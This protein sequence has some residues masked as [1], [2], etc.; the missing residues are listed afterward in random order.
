MLYVSTVAQERSMP[1]QCPR[2]GGKVQRNTTVSK[3][4]G[5]FGALLGAAI[6]PMQC[7]GCGPILTREFPSAVRK[8]I[9]LG[10]IGLV[11]AGVAVLAGAVAVFMLW[12][13]SRQ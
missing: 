4:G 8:R 5:V 9:V 10:S 3:H 11:L 6:G 7:A 2:C 13:R 1:Y 12:R